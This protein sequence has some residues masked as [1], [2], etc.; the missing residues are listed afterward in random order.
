MARLHTDKLNALKRAFTKTP[1]HSLLR[2]DF[3]S[4]V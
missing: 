1:C 3:L 4:N 2:I